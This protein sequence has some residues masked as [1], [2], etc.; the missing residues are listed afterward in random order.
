MQRIQIAPIPGYFDGVAD[1]PLYPGRRGLEGLCHLGVQDFRDG[2]DHIHIP[3]GDNNGFPKILIALDMGG[4]TDLVDDAGNQG[5]NTDLAALADSG[6]DGRL[7]LAKL[8]DP[9]HQSAQIAGLQHQIASTQIG[10]RCGN[11]IR[12]KGR[13]SQD[14]GLT[15]HA[16]NSFQHCQ[17]IPL[18]Q[19]QIQHQNI[20]LLFPYQPLGLLPVHS[21]GDYLKT[22]AALQC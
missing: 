13:C 22:V 4:D 20:R 18:G 12:D 1:G 11:I 2:V 19:H 3:N 7:L 16:G 9:I 14:D 17:P 8:P 5:F 6:D 15:L 10:C 21:G